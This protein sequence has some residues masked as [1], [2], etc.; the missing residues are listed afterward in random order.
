[1]HIGAVSNLSSVPKHPCRAECEY[2]E[3]CLLSYLTTHLKLPIKAA[4]SLLRSL[5][6][7]F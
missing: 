7:A 1:M 2:P 3:R 5:F 6:S 4:M